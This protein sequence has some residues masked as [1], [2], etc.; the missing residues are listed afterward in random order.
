ESR[1]V[2]E[3]A[4]RVA[5]HPGESALAAR[6]GHGLL[7]PAR[8]RVGLA[9]QTRSPAALLAGLDRLPGSPTGD[10]AGLRAC[11]PMLAAIE[12]FAPADLRFDACVEGA[13]RKTEVWSPSRLEDLGTCPQRYFFRR[14]LR[15]DEMEEIPEGYE[16]EPV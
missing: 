1:R 6:D 2:V 8:A 13:G 15:I 10:T 4:T 12:E 11:L 14:V 3:T 5:S 16:L 9:L 7:S